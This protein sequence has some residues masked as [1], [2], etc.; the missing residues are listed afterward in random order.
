MRIRSFVTGLAFAAAVAAGSTLLASTPS[1][2]AAGGFSY[3]A[4]VPSYLYY[5]EGFPYDTQTPSV[6]FYGY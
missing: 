4:P 6:P 3:E 1:F 5:F 2:A